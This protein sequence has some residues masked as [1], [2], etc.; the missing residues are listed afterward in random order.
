MSTVFQVRSHR[1]LETCVHTVLSAVKVASSGTRRSHICFSH[2]CVATGSCPPSTVVICCTFP[3]AAPIYCFRN[4][5]FFFVPQVTAPFMSLIFNPLL[6][7]ISQ[8]HLLFL[9][10]TLLLHCTAHY[11]LF[12]VSS[13]YHW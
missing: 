8:G 5:R 13:K 2:G 10:D 11:S 4:S 6:L 9:R 12:C 3:P 7:L 1:V